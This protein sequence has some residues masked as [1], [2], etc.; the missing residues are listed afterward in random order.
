M[1]FD[2]ESLIEGIWKPWRVFKDSG[3]V[4]GA[5]TNGGRYIG[6][7]LKGI[8]DAVKF[9]GEPAVCFVALVGVVVVDKIRE[10]STPQLQPHKE[11][12]N[13]CEEEV[14]VDLELE[15]TNGNI[16]IGA[17]EDIKDLFG[18]SKFNYKIF[19][20]KYRLACLSSHPDQNNGND[21]LFNEVIK[22]SEEIKWKWFYNFEELDS[23]LK[24]KYE[25]MDFP[26]LRTTSY[27]HKPNSKFS[28][29]CVLNDKFKIICV[30]PEILNA[31][32]CKDI[33]SGEY[34]NLLESELENF[35]G[36]E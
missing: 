30:S 33:H 11:E 1:K 16:T 26:E 12:I 15:F 36:V 13:S 17:K 9:V 6:E 7:T 22:L 21:F 3:G 29:G 28:N 35:I 19:K 8:I 5:C 32:Y 2:R 27:K 20:D 25:S 10:E 4:V 14:W 34:L 31:Y 23:D 24:V 18:L